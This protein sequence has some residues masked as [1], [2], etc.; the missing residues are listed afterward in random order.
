LE[1]KEEE[2]E[3][4]EEAVS[5]NLCRKA[6]SSASPISHGAPSSLASYQE[7][8]AFHWPDV[9][10]SEQQAALHPFFCSPTYVILY[11]NIL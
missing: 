7:V 4:E 10:A 6:A 1:E 8:E 3:E 2:E 11:H 5:P 9:A